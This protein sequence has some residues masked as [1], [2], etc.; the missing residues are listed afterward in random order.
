MKTK[1]QTLV[2]L[3]GAKDLLPASRLLIRIFPIC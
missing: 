2:I 3:R 1:N